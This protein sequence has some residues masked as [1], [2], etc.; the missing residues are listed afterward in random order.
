MEDCRDGRI[1]KFRGKLVSVS[2]YYILKGQNRCMDDRKIILI[3]IPEFYKEVNSEIS[4]MVFRETFFLP[5]RRFYI[6]YFSSVFYAAILSHYSPELY[7][8]KRFPFFTKTWLIVSCVC[9][10]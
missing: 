4:L 1:K 2:Y 7:F 5:V 10:F 8:A 6:V 3:P 9:L